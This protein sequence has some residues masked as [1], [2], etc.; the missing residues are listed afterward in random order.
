MSDILLVEDKES[1]RQMLRMTLEN[2]GYSVDEARDGAEARR[3]L[4]E[5]ASR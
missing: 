1:L 2:A 3:R 5:D 4:N